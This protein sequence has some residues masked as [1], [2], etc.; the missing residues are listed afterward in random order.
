MYCIARQPDQPPTHGLSDVA[1]LTTKPIAIG[2]LAK[3][4]LGKK[5]PSAGRGGDLGCRGGATLGLNSQGCG[6]IVDAQG[7]ATITQVNMAAVIPQRRTKV[8][9]TK[10]PSAI[11][12]GGWVMVQRGHSLELHVQGCGSSV[13]PQGAPTIT[14]V[15]RG[16]SFSQVFARGVRPSRRPVQLAF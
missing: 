12:A 9:N 10:A 13:E 16:C 5:A 6:S 8:E 2:Y 15:K 1:S 14:Q 11:T 4:Q 7:N 3:W